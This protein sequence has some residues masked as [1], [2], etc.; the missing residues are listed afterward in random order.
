MPYPLEPP[1][2]TTYASREDL[3]EQCKNHAAQAGYALSILKSSKVKKSLVLACICYG[4]PANI[5]KLTEENR[6]LPNRSS[7]KT[8]CTMHCVAKEQPDGAWFL[9]VKDGEHNHRPAP[10]GTYA[11][12]RT[13]DS[14]VKERI[15]QDLWAG[16][17]VRQTHAQLQQQFPDLVITKRDIFNKRVQAKVKALQGKTMVEALFTELKEGGYYYP[18]QVFPV[19]HAK[20]GTLSHLLIIHPLSLK[21]YKENSDILILDC[22]YKTNRYNYQL[23]NLVGSTGMNTTFNL[24]ICF[25]H[26]EVC[27]RNRLKQALI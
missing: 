1:L 8:D 18:H 19:D 16:Y 5:W 3:L 27:G 15:A 7:K 2:E 10:L 25:Q 21:I 9:V 20:A 24:G 12:H 22:T 13:R 6:Q 23:L 14:P 17:A 11:V 26:N 4:K